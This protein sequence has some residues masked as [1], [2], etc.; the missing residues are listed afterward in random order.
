MKVDLNKIEERARKY[1]QPVPG[2]HVPCEW[3]L[4]PNRDTG[5]VVVQFRQMHPTPTVAEVV[6]I[7]EFWAP[8]HTEGSINADDEGEMAM[9]VAA[10]VKSGT[11]MLAFLKPVAWVAW[12]PDVVE[13][14]IETLTDK[15]QELRKGAH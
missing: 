4:L 3:R 6:D 7:E 12:P 8:D 13:Q 9:A 15:L 2:G 14:L 10:D 11:V 5:K 1:Y